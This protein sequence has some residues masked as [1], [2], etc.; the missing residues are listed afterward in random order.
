M[1][2]IF[3]L[4]LSNKLPVEQPSPQSNCR[5]AGGGVKCVWSFA[6]DSLIKRYEMFMCQETKHDVMLTVG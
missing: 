3:S 5:P 4:S 6:I 1:H 2:R